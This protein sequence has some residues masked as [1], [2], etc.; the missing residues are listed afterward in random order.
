LYEGTEEEQAAAF[1]ELVQGE[2]ISSEREVVAA[3]CTERQ[4]E[5]STLPA[6]EEQ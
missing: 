3:S 4:A 1:H 6:L 5:I 2:Q